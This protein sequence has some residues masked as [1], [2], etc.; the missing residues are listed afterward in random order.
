MGYFYPTGDK[1]SALKLLHW[2]GNPFSTCVS[3]WSLSQHMLG[4]QQFTPSLPVSR[5]HTHHV[6]YSYRHVSNSNSPNLHLTVV[7]P[8]QLDQS[9]ANMMRTCKFKAQTIIVL[10]PENILLWGDSVN[11]W[12]NTPTAMCAILTLKSG[13]FIKKSRAFAGILLVLATFLL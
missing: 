6:S 4:N 1:Y 9:N 12:A 8:N 3:V 5:R 11:C 2:H 10:Q 7:E 13:F